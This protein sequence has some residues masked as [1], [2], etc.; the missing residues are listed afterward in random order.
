[1]C[2]CELDDVNLTTEDPVHAIHLLYYGASPSVPMLL[3]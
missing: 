2:V 1:M 3:T